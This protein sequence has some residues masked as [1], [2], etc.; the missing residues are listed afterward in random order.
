MSTT[1]ELLSLLE[2]Q[3]IGWNRDGSRGIR[4]YLNLA[5]RMLC[6]VESEQLMIINES[7]G[8][9]PAITTV[10]GTFTY[11]L[12]STVGHIDSVL[13]EANDNS[14]LINNLYR[15]DYGSVSRA[16]QIVAEEITI[17]GIKYIRVPY[18]RAFPATESN[19][20]KIVFTEDPGTTSDIYRYRGYKLP[21]DIVS[22]TIELTIHPPY[23]ML[24]L[25]PATALLL[26]GVQNGNWLDAINTIKEYYIPKM[27]MTF[28]EGAFGTC[29][30][31]EDHGF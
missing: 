2:K 3:F 25:F 28:N 18:I 7:T 24:Y 4:H 20:A 6:D 21:T 26:E 23:D 13:V 22:D 31:A 14:T 5:Q 27:H 10:A 16:S 30:E 8:K 17:S 29:Y 11:S 15:Q 9:L 19:V 12:P 1:E